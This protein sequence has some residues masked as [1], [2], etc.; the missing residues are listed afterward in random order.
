MEVETTEP[1]PSTARSEV[2]VIII[3][4]GLSGL[5]C[6]DELLKANPGL[7]VVVL[8]GSERC[9]GRTKTVELHMSNGK[10][11]LADAG[12]MWLGP[13]HANMLANCA[14]FNVETIPQY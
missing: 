11:A 13:T 6:A 14:R 5:T 9:G 10:Q 1:A 12:G 8:E 3:G 4:A 2:D 7:K